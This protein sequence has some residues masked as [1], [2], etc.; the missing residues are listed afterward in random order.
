MMNLGKRILHGLRW[1]WGQLVMCSGHMTT[2]NQDHQTKDH[3]DRSWEPWDL[4]EW[5]WEEFVKVDTQG[6]EWPQSRLV[7]RPRRRDCGGDT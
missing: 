3:D 1:L 4:S 2:P 7:H 5:T 6:F